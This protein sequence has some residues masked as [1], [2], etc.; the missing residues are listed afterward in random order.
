MGTVGYMSPEQVRGL[1]AD[2]RSDLFSLGAV[3]YEMLTGERAFRGDTAA[4]VMTAILHD[5]P[6]ESH[7]IP[8]AAG[9]VLEGILRHC[10]E[11][12]PDERFQS[13]RDLAFHI[14]SVSAASLP[15]IRMDRPHRRSFPIWMVAAAVILVA[16]ALLLSR[17]RIRPEGSSSRSGAP[18]RISPFLA[19]EAVEREP[20]WSPTGNL[21][22]YVSDAA[23]NDDVWISDPSGANLVNLT[24]DFKGADRHPAWSPE[25]DRIAFYSDRDGGGIYT[26]SAL[27]G[28]ARKRIALKPGILY[29]FGLQWARDGSLVYTNFA[30]DGTKQLFRLSPNETAPA[31]LTCS[32][33]REGTDGGELSPAGD[34]LVFKSFPIGPRAVLY[35][36]RLSSGHLHSEETE[37]D[38]PVW[39][40][41][42]DEIF[43]VSGRDGIPDLWSLSV[44]PTTG[45]RT[46]EPRRLT[47]GAD[48]T[49]FAISP[50][51]ERAIAVRTRT[52]SNLWVFETD[53]EK[54]TEPGQGEPV[55]RGDF[56]D[57]R[58]RWA[59]DDRTVIFESNRRG[60]LDIWK[61]SREQPEP[62]RLTSGKR[63]VADRTRAVDTSQ[64]QV[65]LSSGARLGP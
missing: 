2:H 36:L 11:K 46:A 43:F 52:K 21:I 61:V 38:R 55:T 22:A 32:T 30:A 17:L 47:S 58:P 9:P 24:A 48:L 65:M 8:P 63:S 28:V 10:F 44:D 19:S 13:A 29:T 33:M 18:P 26:M 6:L 5:D 3:L 7:A 16:A 1:P 37:V 15:A 56:R 53:L 40:S 41:K 31:C 14:E 42:G 49:E 59:S 27:G 50:N 51:A 35:L 25:G 45:R 57:G 23:G 12:K 39:S 64:G 60:N 54:V 20:A 4:E 34:F 62:Q